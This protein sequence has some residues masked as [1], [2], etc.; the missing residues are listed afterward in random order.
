MNGTIDLM[1]R[2]FGMGN[3]DYDEPQFFSVTMDHQLA[4]VNVH[5]IKAPVDGESHSFH[6]EGL[7]QHLLKDARGLR[8][9]T[10]AIKN[11]LDHG[12]D[13]R[14]RRLCPALDAYREMVVSSR[15][16]ANPRRQRH[17][18]QSE[19][20]PTHAQRG[21][22]DRP[23]RD[24]YV[25]SPLSNDR[26]HHDPIVQESAAKSSSGALHSTTPSRHSIDKPANSRFASPAHLASQPNTRSRQSVDKPATRSYV[27]QAHA[28]LRSNIR[29]RHGI[30]DANE[31]KERLVRPLQKSTRHA[32]LD[33]DGK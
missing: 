5:W 13:P 1:Q 27:S 3:F 28:A 31:R 7:S 21:G 2:S 14:L 6:I 9:L 18:A 26:H 22:D 33:G 32:R 4:C 15:K 8:A 24:A 20:H 29:S 11:I 25:P 10:R 23:A 12:A 17:E 16:A 30:D 19:R